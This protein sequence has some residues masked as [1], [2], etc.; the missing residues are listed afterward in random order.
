MLT[1]EL[2]I[3]IL[4]LIVLVAVSFAVSAI[5]THVLAEQV[6]LAK[7]PHEQTTI[8][9][10]RATAVVRLL[11]LFILSAAVVAWLLTVVLPA[12]AAV[13][14]FRSQIRQYLSG[15]KA[16][17]GNDPLSLLLAETLNELDAARRRLLASE[18]MAALGFFAGG[19]AHQIGN[20]LS[21]ARQYAEVL[22][23]QSSGQAAELLP[24][25]QLQLDRMQAA[26]EG[27][28]RLARP[29]RLSP[30]VI[31][32]QALLN[33]AL[34][35]IRSTWP[36]VFD[37]ELC[38]FLSAKVFTDRL[39]VVQAL[40]NFMRNA[41]EAQGQANTRIQIE[42]VDEGSLVR[43]DIRDFGPGF[44]EGFRPDAVL[45]SDKLGG[46]G[47]GIPLAVRLIDLV[48]GTVAFSNWSSGALVRIT[49]PSATC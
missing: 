14:S 19:I 39:A 36:G 41:S 31:S 42:I 37:A 48:G 2:R 46:T 6:R 28:L 11:T 38:G 18:R 26:I 20:P 21:A 10:E 23:L 47:L 1:R 22:R 15:D 33:E 7:L 13:T 3:Q 24:R 27:L 32:V 34:E 16:N 29:E 45:E 12:R 17:K 44:P 30:E 40:L 4:G 25:L 5:T 8:M 35:Q 43:L 49:L 9:I